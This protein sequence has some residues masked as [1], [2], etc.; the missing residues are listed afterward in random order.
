MTELRKNYVALVN[1]WASEED[2][3]EVVDLIVDRMNKLGAYV[4]SVYTMEVTLPSLRFRYEGEEYRDKVMALDSR[5]RSAHE[6]AIAAVAQLTRW[7][8]AVGVD[9]MFVGDLDDRYAI[10]DFCM[11]AVKTFFRNGRADHRGTDE[12]FKEVH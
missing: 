11:E 9:P 3:Q 12:E 6:A 7:A 1:A 8:K 10:A 5:R 4:E 2:G